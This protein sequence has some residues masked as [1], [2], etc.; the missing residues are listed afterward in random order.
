MVLENSLR[1]IDEF[2]HISERLRKIALQSAIGGM[3]LST[4]AMVVA[5]AGHLSP[6]TG[7]VTQECIDL[8]SILNAL[9]VAFPPPVLSEV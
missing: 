2:M 4:A 6:V 1:R 7:A 8:L 9:R 5:A 3:L